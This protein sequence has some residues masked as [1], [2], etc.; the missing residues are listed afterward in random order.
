MTAV[1]VDM[2]ADAM[3]TVAVEAIVGMIVIEATVEEIET[4][5]YHVELIVTLV[6]TAMVVEEMMIVEVGEDILIDMIEVIGDLGATRHQ[7]LDS[8]SPSLVAMDANRTEV[9]A[10]TMTECPVENINYL[11]W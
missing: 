10:M 4:I 3:T 7:P 5:I 9:G 1:V 2:E 8:T 11:P 6:M